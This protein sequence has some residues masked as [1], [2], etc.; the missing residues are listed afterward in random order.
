M[1]AATCTSSE[2]RRAGTGL[3]GLFP[4]DLP[5][6]DGTFGIAL[7]SVVGDGQDKLGGDEWST[8]PDNL[9]KKGF[10]A[11]VPGSL[12]NRANS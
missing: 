6:F 11:R 12:E 9:L 10:D 5:G 8:D 7:D 2:A 3:P 4:P 1:V